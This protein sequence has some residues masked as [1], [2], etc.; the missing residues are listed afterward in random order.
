MSRPR[1]GITTSYENGVQSVDHHYVKAV[2]DAGGLPVILPVFGSQETSDMLS[3]ML[4][5]LIITGGPGITR[6]LLDDLPED[7]PPV[8]PLRDQSDTLIYNAFRS[9]ER[10]VM[11]ICYGMQFINAQTGGTIY[12]DL[13]R[14]IQTS[15]QHSPKRGGKEHPI[16]LEVG[17]RLRDVMGRE[18]LMSNTYHIQS[19]AT[20]G[21]GLKPAAYS[22]DGVVEAIESEGGKLLGLQFHP[23]RMTDITAPLF[24]DFVERCRVAVH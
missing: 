2:E 9:D 22:P 21:A 3:Q 11:G 4:D 24:S 19:V 14:H 18:E 8:D 17:S 15:I 1:I 6:G 13:A 10:P 16:K 12:G 23:E 7:L 5:G 20:L